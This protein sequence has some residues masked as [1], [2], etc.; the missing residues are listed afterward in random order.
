MMSRKRTFLGLRCKGT[1]KFRRFQAAG[2]EITLTA[3]SL[4]DSRPFS[5]FV[6]SHRLFMMDGMQGVGG[7]IR[8][9]RPSRFF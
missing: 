4:P 9:A 2:T 5:V 1:H 3:G 8:L 7:M 6:P